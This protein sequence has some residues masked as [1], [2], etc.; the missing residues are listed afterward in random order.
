VAEVLLLLALFVCSATVLSLRYWVLPNI[1]SYRTD[2]ATAITGAAGQRV[3]IAGIVADW[4]GLRPHLVL[5]DVQVYDQRGRQAL[6]LNQVEATLSWWSLLVGE[7]RLDALEIAHPGLAVRRDVSGLVYVAGIAVNRTD[8]ESTFP[9]WVLKQGRIEIRDAT[10]LWQDELRGAPPLVLS[11][12]N[13]RI[14]NHGKRHNFGLQAVP[15]AELAKPIDLRGELKGATVRDLS[16]WQGKLYGRLDYTDLAAWRQWVTLPFALNN[17]YGGLRFWLDLEHSIVSSLV[18]DVRLSEV[19]A[20]LAPD[21]PEMDLSTL[22]GRLSWRQVKSGGWFT[23]GPIGQEFHAAQLSLVLR[24]GVSIPSADI[25]ARF[26]P[27]DSKNLAQGMLKAN[28][29]DLEM[30]SMVAG[31]LPL[32]AEG[33]QKLGEFAPRGSF[34]DLSLQ[35]SGDLAAPAQYAIKGNFDLLGLRPVGKLPGFAGLSGN[36]DANQQG[37]NLSVKGRA[38]SLEFPAV[39]RAPLP[40]DTLVAQLGWKVKRGAIDLNLTNIAF[41]NADLAGSVYGNYQNNYSGPGTIELTGKFTRA[42]ARSAS[43]YI[44]LVLGADAIA[45]LDA[46][47][48]AGQSNDVRLRLKGNLADFP[49]V[50][51]KR[52]LFQVNAKVTGAVLNYANGWPQIENLNGDLL[53][54]GKR[55]EVVAQR[56]TIMGAKLGRVSAV[57]PDLL[58]FDERLDIVGEAQ[59][60]TGEFLKFI[61]HSPVA[62]MIDHATDDMQATGSGKLVLKLHLPLRH[63]KDATLAGA[64]QFLNNRF[65][66]SEGMPAL[67][68]VNGKLEFSQSGIKMQNVSAQIFGGP[69]LLNAESLKD[70]SVRLSA[71]GR[72]NAVGLRKAVDSPLLSHVYGAA[73]WRVQGAFRPNQAEFVLDSSL[74]GIASDL[75]APFNKTAAEII[76]LRIEGKAAPAKTG[77]RQQTIAMSYGRLVSALLLHRDSAEGAYFERGAITFGGTAQLPSQRGIWVSGTLPYLDFDQWG[78][79]FDRGGSQSQSTVAGINLNFGTLDALGKRFNA[80]HINAWAEKDGWQALVEGA[81]LSGDITWKPAPAEGKVSGHGKVTARFKTLTLPEAV[82]ARPIVVVARQVREL[83]ALDITADN[84]QIKQRK[85]GKL[86]LLASQQERKWQIK[87]LKVTNPDSTLTMDGIWQLPGVGE[88]NS[89]TRVNL[90]LEANDVGKFMARMGFPDTVKRGKAKLEGH[91]SWAGGPADLDFSSLSGDLALDAHSG[92][93]VKAE[94]GIGKLLG[95]LS[96]QSLPR[97]ITLDFRDVFSDGFA[98]E[99]I[100]GSMRVVQ[101]MIYSDDFKMQGSAALVTMSGEADLAKETQKLKV[102]IIPSVGDSVSVVAGA[103][104]GGPVVGVAAMLLQKVLKDPLGRV[105][106][107]HYQITGTWSDPVVTKITSANGEPS[108]EK[109]GE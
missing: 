38:V 79:L 69:A 41:A 96:L 32:P 102:R 92:Q 99:D 57:I 53:F 18:A 68:Q 90:K 11:K 85:L 12:L 58:T 45:W 17:G 40:L 23:A 16:D 104:L 93:F 64:Y 14:E 7:L 2:I 42:D 4:E 35:W 55:M 100:S 26:V 105:I 30:L 70:S 108:A 65:V 49:F 50:D 78:G 9:D 82:P 36:V 77:G 88:T 73:D 101:G 13:L 22:G 97:R 44:P 3:T 94:P 61:S 74:Q 5:R 109:K 20:R 25:M 63:G 54:Q 75:P 56:A 76:P 67:E 29:L 81:G 62:G 47:F 34:R 24:G 33:R 19:K 43:R 87:E 71:Q 59:G 1:E 39:F 80:L 31:Y 98:F 46:A 66:A 10:V 15:P 60:P 52:G 8:Q 27:A 51:N 21:L 89:L 95:I 86:E 103:F 84:F 106:S 83:P 37:G 6:I 91:L 72:F 48:L 107:Y 28:H